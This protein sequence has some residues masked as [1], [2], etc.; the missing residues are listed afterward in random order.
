MVKLMG[1]CPEGFEESIEGLARL[2]IPSMDLYG[3][4]NGVYEPA[5]APVFYNP[6]M[7]ENRDIAVGTV[8]YL[9]KRSM[10]LSNEFVVVDPLAA[11]GVRG[12]R[13]LVEIE[14]VSNLRVYMSDISERCVELMKLNAQLNGL[15]DRIE[16]EKADANELLYRLRRS[17]VSLSY[18]DIDPFGSPVPFVLSAIATVRSGGVTAFTATDLAV[19][20]GKY[21]GKMLR[22]YGL[23]GTKSPVSKDIA[24]RVLISYIARIAYSLDRYVEPVISYLYKHY[25]RVYLRVRDGASKADKQLRECLRALEVCPS[26]GYSYSVDIEEERRVSNTCPLCGVRMSVVE[27][28]WIC[29]IIDTESVQG[30]FQSLYEKPWVRSSSKD[31]MKMLLDCAEVN[32]V[33]VRLSMVAK[34]LK[35][36][37]PPRDKV[38]QCLKGIGFKAVKSYTYGDG[39]ITTASIRDIVKCF[40]S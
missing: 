1:V 36:N 7:V 16:I 29:R 27:P 8:E 35:I 5:W 6:E 32:G 30:I 39:I 21:R 4:A 40:S 14:N 13:I 22:R 25:V 20:E 11:T 38:I 15:R 31:L 18:I 3:R 10:P 28:L 9:V 24:V 37:T 33:S 23:A 17:G 2:C 12:I 26:C 34:A 19:L